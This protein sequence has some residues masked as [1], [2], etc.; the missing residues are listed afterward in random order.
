MRLM[1]LIHAV[2]FNELKVAQEWLRPRDRKE[3]P[4]ESKSKTTAAVWSARSASGTLV[5]CQVE[6]LLRYAQLDNA[7]E[8][9]TGALLLRMGIG[10]LWY[11]Q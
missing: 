4:L 7:A 8:G 6:V 9:M 10:T 11:A 3:S 2:V 1:L 5:T